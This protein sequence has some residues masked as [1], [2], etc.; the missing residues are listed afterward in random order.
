[1]A[2]SKKAGARDRIG[3]KLAR[4]PPS[5][6]ERAGGLLAPFLSPF[7]LCKQLGIDERTPQRWVAAGEAPPR[8][9]IGVRSWY[10]KGSVEAWL[11]AR[12]E[13]P[14]ASRRRA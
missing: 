4:L 8:T 14:E 5:E 1:M 7:D 6:F 9:V 3:R 2:R 13:A 12:E 10:R 11:R